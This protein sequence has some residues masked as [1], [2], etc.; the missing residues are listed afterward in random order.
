MGLRELR[1]SGDLRRHRL[2]ARLHRRAH[3]RHLRSR[4]SREGRLHPGQAGH[5]Q[6]R[7]QGRPHRDAPLQRRDPD[8][9]QR[10]VRVT[11]PAAALRQRRRAHPRPGRHHD[12]GRDRPDEAQ[13]LAPEL[14]RVPGAQHLHL[15]AG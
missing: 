10:A 4:R 14:P 8:R 2:L 3:R 1:L 9:I 11:V 5:A 7:R 12:L 13:G 6:Q 15:P